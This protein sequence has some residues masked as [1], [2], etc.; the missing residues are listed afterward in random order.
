MQR[1]T[2]I[3]TVVISVLTLSWPSF[4]A[5]NTQKEGLYSERTESGTF[6][7]HQL[8]GLFVLNQDGKVIGEIQAVNFDSKTGKITSV[9]I[10]E[11]TQKDYKPAQDKM[12]NPMLQNVYDN[13]GGK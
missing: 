13:V 2:I 1:S 3:L 7:G 8:R 9:T 6:T 10:K 11:L 4:A 5:N 12:Q